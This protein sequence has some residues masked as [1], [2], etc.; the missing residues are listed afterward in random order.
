[1]HHGTSSFLKPPSYT[2]ADAVEC[3]RL[4]GHTKADFIEADKSQRGMAEGASTAVYA[5]Y[6]EKTHALFAMSLDSFWL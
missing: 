3:A 1:M 4:H 5:R 2:F 6:L